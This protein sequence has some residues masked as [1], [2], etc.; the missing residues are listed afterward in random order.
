MVY[1][2]Y[3][4]NL[5]RIDY[6]LSFPFSLLTSIVSIFSFSVLTYRSSVLR[7]MLQLLSPKYL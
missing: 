5:H 3:D 4:D 2:V 1:M 6:V 7:Q